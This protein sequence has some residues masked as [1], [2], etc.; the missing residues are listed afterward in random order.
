M[1]SRLSRRFYLLVQIRTAVSIFYLV[2]TMPGPLH[3]DR[4]LPGSTDRASTRD[5]VLVGC[6]RRGGAHDLRRRCP[7]ADLTIP[8]RQAIGLPGCRTLARRPHGAGRCP[9]LRSAPGGGALPAGK[10]SATPDCRPCS[11]SP[12]RE[13]RSDRLAERG[14]CGSLRRHPRTPSGPTPSCGSMNDWIYT[15]CQLRNTIGVGRLDFRQNYLQIYRVPVHSS[16]AQGRRREHRGRDRLLPAFARRGRRRTGGCEPGAGHHR[17]WDPGGPRA[18]GGRRSPSRPAATGS[19]GAWIS[20]HLGYSGAS[21]RW[22]VTCAA[23]GPG[24]WSRLWGMPT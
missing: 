11:A 21:L 4:R 8:R 3:R 23:S 17:A 2:P 24:S 13:A 10:T 16:P 6:F 14:C 1:P 7:D 15:N 19:A 18:G 22:P 9:L 20:A 5:C 12:R